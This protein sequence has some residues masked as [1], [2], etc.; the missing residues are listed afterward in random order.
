MAV[1]IAARVGA[2]AEPGDVLVSGAIPPLVVG[3]AIV[4]TDFGEHELKGIPG[5]WKL[6]AAEV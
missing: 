3:S 1:H 4:F 5:N 2:L 6:Y